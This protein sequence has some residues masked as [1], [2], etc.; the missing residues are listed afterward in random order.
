MNY[1]TNYRNMNS[2]G[3]K[4]SKLNINEIFDCGVVLWCLRC[5]LWLVVYQHNLMLSLRAMK[6]LQIWLRLKRKKVQHG[7]NRMC[8]FVCWWCLKKLS[9]IFQLYRGGQFYWCRKP[10]DPEKTMH[11]PVV[12][13]WQTVSHNVVQLALFEIQ[14]HNI[15]N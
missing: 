13:H 6:S 1:S 5:G 3:D 7:E 10:Q 2:I 11:R 4:L 12:G 9:I 15:R 14:I 8:L